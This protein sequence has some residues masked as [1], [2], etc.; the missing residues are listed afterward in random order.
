MSD[1]GI[2][3]T[4]ENQRRNKGISSAL[5]WKLYEIILND[6]RIIR[7]I[8]SLYETSC[9]LIRERPDF[10]VAQNPSILLASYAVLVKY[11]LRYKCIIDAHNSGLFPYDNKKSLFNLISKNIQK[12]SD[13]TI[14]TNGEL[15]KVVQNNK[16]RAVILPDKIPDPPGNITRAELKGRINF[17]FICS[18]NPD[19]PYKEVI[20]AARLIPEDIYIY[21]TGK[22]IGKVDANNVPLNVKLLGYIPDDEYWSLISSVDGI[23]ILTTRENCLVCGAYE[24][25]SLKKPMILSNTNAIKTYFSLGSVYTEPNSRDIQ[26]AMLSLIDNKDKLSNEVAILERKLRS[27]WKDSLADLSKTITML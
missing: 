16:G 5:E 13:L 6:T 10:V 1:K 25:V 20:E 7:Y 9:I 21:V 11:I 17:A 3:I 19:E 24:A 22:Y 26:D 14:V 18:F 4:W 23:V 15:A 8:K 27:D 12:L 2:W